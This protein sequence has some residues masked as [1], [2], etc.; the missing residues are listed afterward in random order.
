MITFQCSDQLRGRVAGPNPCSQALAACVT[1]DR[2]TEGTP[3]SHVLWRQVPGSV[4]SLDTLFACWI[5]VLLYTVAVCLPPGLRG[6]GAY[7]LAILAALTV[8]LVLRFRVWRRRQR[9]KRQRQQRK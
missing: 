1:M 9:A 5:A 4:V 8:W 6:Q 2:I 7:Y 3:V